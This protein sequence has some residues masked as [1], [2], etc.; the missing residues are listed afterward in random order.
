MHD[1][2]VQVAAVKEQSVAVV[3][4]EVRVTEDE[5]PVAF[6]QADAVHTASDQHFADG[7]LGGLAQFDSRSLGVPAEDLDA[8]DCREPF[9][10]P[11]VVLVG[12]RLGGATVIADNPQGRSRSVHDDPRCA[13]GS[14]DRG[15]TGSGGV[16]HDGA[17]DAIGTFGEFQHSVAGGQR[18]FER[19]GV[20]ALAVTGC[21]EVIHKSHQGVSVR[22]DLQR[23]V[24]LDQPEGPTEVGHRFRDVRRWIN[25]PAG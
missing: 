14:S 2:L 12:L 10:V 15:V 4:Q 6:H 7:C 5:V 17:G 13:P 3:V 1:D 25:P 21:S 18:V 11:G 16:D 19:F 22:S 20:V 24:Y 23:G 8:T 9:L